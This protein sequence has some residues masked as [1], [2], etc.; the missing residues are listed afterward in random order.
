LNKARELDYDENGIDHM[1]AVI[2]EI[3]EIGYDEHIDRNKL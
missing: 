2:D 3:I 1:Y